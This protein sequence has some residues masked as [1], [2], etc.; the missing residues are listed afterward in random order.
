MVDFRKWLLA[1]AAVGLLLGIGSSAANAQG[2]PHLHARLLL[3]FPTSSA[4]RELLSWL[5]IWF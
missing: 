4:R 2:T 3:A 1:L 5:A